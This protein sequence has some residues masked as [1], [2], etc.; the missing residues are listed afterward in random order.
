MNN[1][2]IYITEN[3]I[4]DDVRQYLSDKTGFN[5]SSIT[6]NYIKEIPKNESGKTSYKDLSR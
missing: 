6:I 4:S 1:L 3:R 5:H 2:Y